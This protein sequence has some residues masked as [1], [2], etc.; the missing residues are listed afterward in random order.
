[1]PVSKELHFVFECMEGNL[2]QLTKSRKGRPLAAGLVASIFQ[3]IVKG[4]HHIHDQGYFHRDMKP[5]N[6]LITTTGLADYPPPLSLT[7]PDLAPEKDVLVIVKLADFGLARETDSKPP[8]TEYVSTRWYRAPEV[9]LRSRDYSNPVDMWALGTI[10]AE[11]ITLKPLFPGQTEID[12]VMQICEILGDPVR[13][14]GR[15]TRG[16]LKGGGEWNGGVR[17]AKGVGFTFPPMAPI[18]FSSLFS[19]KVPE[20]LIDC[21]QDL[22]RYDPARRLTTQ[23]CLLHPYYTD[24]APRLQPAQARAVVSATLP[25]QQAVHAKVVPKT[26]M[27]TSIGSVMDQQAQRSNLPPSHSISLQ[28]KRLA[29]GASQDDGDVQMGAASPLGAGEGSMSA[30]AAWAPALGLAPRGGMSM[31]QYPSYPDSVSV[32]SG[33]D[34]SMQID[35]SVYPSMQSPS[36]DPVR[37]ASGELEMLHESD[38]RRMQQ[39][40]Q[41]NYDHGHVVYRTGRPSAQSSTQIQLTP[42][43][44]P[45][46]DTEGSRSTEALSFK[47]KDRGRGK[48]W[49]FLGAVPG[50]KPQH[51][52]QAPTAEIYSNEQLSSGL[53]APTPAQKLAAEH[54]DRKSP[55]P[56]VEMSPAEAKKAKK[57]ADKAAREA[58]KAKRAAQEKAARERARAVMQKRNQILASSNTRD[59]VEWL[60]HAD[61]ETAKAALLPATGT[62]TVAQMYPGG[63]Q[64]N[65]LPSTNS[66]PTLAYPSPHNMGSPYSAYS[67]QSSQ[68]NSPAWPTNRSSSR[69]KLRKRDYEEESVMNPYYPQGQQYSRN[70]PRRQS[71]QSFQTGDSDPGPGRTIYVAGSGLHH[72]QRQD[73]TSSL[74]SAPGLIDAASISSRTRYDDRHSLDTRSIA[75]SLDHQLIQNMENM[76]AAERGFRHRTGSTSPGPAHL[77]GQRSSLSRQSHGSRASSAHRQGSA[78]PLHHTS[79]TSR[80][81]PYGVGVPNGTSYTLPSLASVAQTS[82]T[83][84]DVQ[85]RPKSLNRRSSL[86]HHRGIV[87]R[88]SVASGEGSLPSIPQGSGLASPVHPMFHVSPDSPASTILSTLSSPSQQHQTLPPFSQLAAAAASSYSQDGHKPPLEEYYPI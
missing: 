41:I 47:D 79:T 51:S 24:V 73:S 4:L 25:E 61:N 81:H 7:I 62:P 9:L 83:M 36:Y 34:A 56:P 68:L 37:L 65:F 58:E 16:R 69:G 27:I 45:S 76:T 55:V 29:P 5:E 64:P 85:A 30:D 38:P 63:K 43:L 21:V 46:G 40:S 60:S 14:Y 23:Q 54:A 84:G 59:Q 87:S 22:I 31:S 88:G 70:N 78:S 77:I 3:Q 67:G 49:G 8:Y 15:D 75:S 13:D 52:P 82:A 35:H 12:Q 74:N 80:F 18:Q 42:G 11:L 6:L 39:G 86:S 53:V 48:G 28:A 1:M 32:F 17:M 66:D 10:L 20:S 57:L 19:S 50:V 26:T 44:T 2:Y 72:M 71:M 33:N